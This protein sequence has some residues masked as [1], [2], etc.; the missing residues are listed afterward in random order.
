MLREEAPAEGEEGYDP[1][2]APVETLRKEDAQMFP[3]LGSCSLFGLYCAFKFL[4]QD[5]VN[6]LISGYFA[7]VGC[8]ALTMTIAPLAEKIAPKSMNEKEIGGKKEIS[9]PLPD[10]FMPSPVEIGVVFTLTEL[11]SFFLSAGIVGLYFKTRYWA[12]NNVLGICFCIQGIERLSL[13]TYWIGA[14]LLIGLFFYDIFWVFGTDVMVTVAKNLDGPIKLLFPRSLT[15]DEATGRI[16]LSLLGLGDI[17]IPGFFLALLLRFDA[18]NANMP[19]TNINIH[20][21]FSKP[22]FH[23]AMIAYFLGLGTTLFVMIQFRAAQPALLYLVPACLG[24]S[25]LCAVVRGEVTELLAYSEEVEEEEE[26]EEQEE[27]DEKKEKSD[28]DKKKD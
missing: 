20:E 22:Y 10:W 8:G 18:H 28:D 12:L 6:L 21:N 16:E 13:G 15:P 2:A 27:G 7:A 3:I 26:E 25:F 23:S 24:S 14:I 4:G 19:T 9:H 1:D 5:L 17:V 11:A